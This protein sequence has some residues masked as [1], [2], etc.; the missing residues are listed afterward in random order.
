MGF[1]NN[2]LSIFEVESLIKYGGLLIIFL[3]VYGSTGLF[4]CFFIP[5]GAVLFT[6]GIF[7][8]TGQ[9]HYD[10]FSI[11]NLLILASVLG[12]LTGYWFGWK[13][14]VL[15]HKWEDSRFYKK[16][17]LATAE[18]FYKKYG[19]TALT[20]GLFLPIVRTF[21]PIVSGIVRLNF[22]RFILLTIGGSVFWIVSF[23]LA[24]YLIGSVPSLKPWLKYIV[25]FII[26]AVTIP[27]IIWLTKELRMLRKE[28][29]E[30]L[31]E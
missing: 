6:T 18:T 30:K 24:G 17:H 9:L 14:G 4:F 26:V 25:L 29:K 8:A 2:L 20:L 13:T 16:H 11:C 12:N 5:T 19:W 1:F 23:V 21:S 7:A 15:L 22:R 27:I 3:L 28:N 31:K 10:I